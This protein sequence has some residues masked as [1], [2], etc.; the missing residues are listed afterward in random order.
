[1]KIEYGPVSLLLPEMPVE[2]E[3]AG[4]D[5]PGVYTSRIRSLAGRDLVLEAP[6]RGGVYVPLRPETGLVVRASSR[7]GLLSFDTAVVDRQAGETPPLLVVSRPARLMIVQRR[8]CYRVAAGLPVVWG[9][10]NTDAA[11][12]QAAIAVDLSCGGA[13]LR[14]GPHAPPLRENDRVYLRLPVQGQ[15]ASDGLLVAAFVVGVGTRR[16]RFDTE[17]VVR[18]RFDVLSRRDEDQIGRLIHALDRERLKRRRA[19]SSAWD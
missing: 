11:D 8:A 19:S 3:A 5:W 1:M 10:E 13:A 4:G 12:E 9:R 17:R 15:A 7:N 16:V 2:I 18:I 6:I 14:C